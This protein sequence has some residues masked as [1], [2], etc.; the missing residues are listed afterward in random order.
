MKD[1]LDEIRETV[2]ELTKNLIVRIDSICDEY[3]DG[4]EPANER[5]I[6]FLDDLDTLME[7][8]SLVEASRDM[9]ANVQELKDK[10]I[11]MND[12]LE[13]EDQVLLADIL[14]FEL[15]PLLEYWDSKY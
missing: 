5:L 11:L 15:K 9:P 13:N 14:R 2:R 12:A 8:I 4:P 6:F 1:R 10:L 3:S 7:G